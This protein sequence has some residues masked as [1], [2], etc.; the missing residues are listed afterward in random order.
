MGLSVVVEVVSG[1][2]VVVVPGPMVVV[3]DETSEAVDVVVVPIESGSSSSPP[4]ATAISETSETMRARPRVMA[5]VLHGWEV[6]AKRSR[7]STNRSR[8]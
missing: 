3:V 4:P 8:Y 6:I 2:S 5:A 1:P 7:S